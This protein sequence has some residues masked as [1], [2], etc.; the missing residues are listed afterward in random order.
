MWRKAQKTLRSNVLF[1]KRH[2]GHQYLMRGLTKCG[3][4]GLTFIGSVMYRPSGTI[5]YYRRNG[6]R[7]MRLVLVEAS[8]IC[9]SW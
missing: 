5:E 3:P 7:G 6:K 9:L 2:S 1:S 8:G 4:R